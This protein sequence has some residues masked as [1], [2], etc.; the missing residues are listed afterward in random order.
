[1]GPACVQ[2]DRLLVRRMATLAG[3]AVVDPGSDEEEELYEG[4]YLSSG[5]VAA[6]AQAKRLASYA[7]HAPF[8]NRVKVGH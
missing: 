4:L 5:L 1:M 3:S 8:E 6:E 2:D 7:R